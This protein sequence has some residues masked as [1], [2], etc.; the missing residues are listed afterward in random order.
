MHS[1][2]Q[3]LHVHVG[4]GLEGHGDLP[5]DGL[6]ISVDSFRD[7]Y[8]YKSRC[9]WHIVLPAAPDYRVA[10]AHQKAITGFHT[11]YRTVKIRQHSR[12]APINDVQEQPVVSVLE[13]CG[14]EDANIC[15][16]P[17]QAMRIPWGELQISNT[18]MAGMV[19]VNSEVH[20]AIQLF[21]WADITKG[22]ALRKGAAGLD[23]QG[24]DRHIEPPSANCS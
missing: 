5:Y 14:L 4:I 21:V 22:C 18:G 19:R 13:H 24:C 12:V 10:L 9:G 2:G 3:E 7:L 8:P 17:H 6:S 23:L 15:P 1:I 20:C 16:A 11:A